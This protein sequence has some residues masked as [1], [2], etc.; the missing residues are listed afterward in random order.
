MG[1]E[2][3][4]PYVGVAATVYP[5]HVSGIL[6]MATILW[7]Q[8]STRR[9]IAAGIQVSHDSLHDRPTAYPKRFPSVENLERWLPRNFNYLSDG[10]QVRQS[11]IH[12]N[13][14]HLHF[15]PGANGRQHLMADLDELGTRLGHWVHG[16]QVND[17]FPN[18]DALRE[19]SERFPTHRIILTV[20]RERT[21]SGQT[22]EELAGEIKDLY[23]AATNL[24]FDQ[25]GGNGEPLEVAVASRWLAAISQQNPELGLG[26]AGGFGPMRLKGYA[27][28]LAKF[29]QLSLDAERWLLYSEEHGLDMVR[30]NTFIAQVGFLDYLREVAPQELPQ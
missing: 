17:N 29:N 9:H 30:A 28:L 26:V 21:E 4:P 12:R 23:S 11:V 15:S 13:E 25:S 6:G 2:A 24:L 1:T 16:I 19:W 8:Y 5:S 14:I 20:G 3:R 22:P 10:Y 7:N 18:P 27:Q